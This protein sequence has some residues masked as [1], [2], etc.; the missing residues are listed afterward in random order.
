MTFSDINFL[1][2]FI[3]IFVPIYAV[4]PQKVKPFMLLAGGIGFYA[5]NDLWFLPTLLIDILIVFLI[6]AFF[7]VAFLVRRV[8]VVVVFLT[9]IVVI[10]FTFS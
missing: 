9:V 10:L 4:L 2:I 3:L 1:L 5:L 6:I 8:F 7:V